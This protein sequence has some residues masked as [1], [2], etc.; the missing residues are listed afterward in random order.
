MQMVQIMETT[1]VHLEDWQLLRAQMSHLKVPLKSL[2]II[3]SSGTETLKIPSI[4][5]SCSSNNKETSKI[6]TLEKQKRNPL[7]PPPKSPTTIVIRFHPVIQKR[8]NK[9][10]RST[11]H[12]N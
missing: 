10:C 4:E 1:L 6:N 11:R 8:N 5:E 7:F 3:A 2:A 12:R 9:S